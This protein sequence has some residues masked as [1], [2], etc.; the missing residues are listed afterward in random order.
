[1]DAADWDIVVECVDADWAG[2]MTLSAAQ[3]EYC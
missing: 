3:W 2:F 1:M